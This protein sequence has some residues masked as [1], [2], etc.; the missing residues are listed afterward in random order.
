MEEAADFLGIHI[1]LEQEEKGKQ[2]QQEVA[3]MA[4]FSARSNKSSLS[5]SSKNIK[6]PKSEPTFYMEPKKEMV[7][8]EDFDI[9]KGQMAK[10]DSL[11]SCDFCKKT[12][13][14]KKHLRRHMHSSHPDMASAGDIACNV[15]RVHFK[16]GHMVKHM[17]S[18][19]P[20]ESVKY[21]A[22]LKS[23]INH[24][25]MDRTECRLCSK[26]F[27]GRAFLERHISLQHPDQLV[28]AENEL[29]QKV[30]ADPEP[31]STNISKF[32]CNQC[33]K[34]LASSSALK[35]HLSIHLE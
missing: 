20:E 11:N 18:K 2:K 19:H 4:V 10:A 32:Q 12:F 1:N 7:D 6:T 16:K 17:K 8:Q 3:N 24:K 30:M 22:Q 13:S 25:E 5:I 21:L 34:Y 35:T 9:K 29:G 26:A 28:L 31:L 15:C 33:Q 23:T 27:G 14:K